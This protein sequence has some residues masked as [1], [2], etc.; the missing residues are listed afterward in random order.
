MPPKRKTQEAKARRST[1]KKAKTSSSTQQQSSMSANDIQEVTMNVIKTLKEQ[2]LLKTENQNDVK[3]SAVS[4]DDVSSVAS[5]STR[6]SYNEDEVHFRPVD[7]A[8]GVLHDLT[9]ESHSFYS[10]AG[11]SNS[12][13][14]SP[15]IYKEKSI[16][17]SVPAHPSSCSNT[18]SSSTTQ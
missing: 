8:S 1:T 3:A 5:L 4:H 14:M 10:E 2:G 15:C 17:R 16:T 9:G 11:P 6:Q 18:V 7:V 12:R 13:S